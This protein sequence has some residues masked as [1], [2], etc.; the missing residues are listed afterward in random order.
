MAAIA[1]ATGT[2]D[3]INRHPPSA[4]LIKEYLV[5][6]CSLQILVPV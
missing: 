4:A 2:L 3:H 6:C 5:L 1:M